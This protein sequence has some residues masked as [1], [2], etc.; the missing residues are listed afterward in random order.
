M[1]ASVG[2]K[3]T[4][5]VL[6]GSFAGPVYLINPKHRRIAGRDCFASIDALPAT[7]DLA[8]IATPPEHHPLSDR[9]RSERRARAR[10]SSITAGLDRDLKQAMLDAARPTCL[11]IIGPNCLGIW[12][13]ALGVNAN[14]RHGGSGA[15]QACLP[16][17][18]RSLVGGGARL[19]DIARHRLLY[20][21]SMGEMA[22]VDVG[23]LL[24]FLAADISTGAILLF[25]S[26]PFPRRASSCRRAGPPP[27]P[28]RWW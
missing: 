1:T 25:T 11:R 27:A 3:L 23:D 28:S 16:V 7:P 26:R 21:V 10:R 15:G 8:V 9:G 12:V 19:G 20:V 6:D 2:E 17:A 22:D 18:V 5:N 4:E 14:F 13:P 24:D